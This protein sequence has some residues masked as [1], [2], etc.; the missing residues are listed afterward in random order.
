MMTS[1]INHMNNRARDED[2]EIDYG[3]SKSQVKRECDHLT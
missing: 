3:P 2:E 1:E